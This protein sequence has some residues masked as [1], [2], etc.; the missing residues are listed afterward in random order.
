MPL[1]DPKKKEINI[2]KKEFQM[3]LK[4]RLRFR[5]ESFEKGQHCKLSNSM[6]SDNYGG[7]VIIDEESCTMI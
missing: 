7:Y 2:L 1:T 6:G 5:S 3:V 4:G